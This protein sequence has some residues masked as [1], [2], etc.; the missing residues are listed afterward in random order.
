M[1]LVKLVK[2]AGVIGADGGGYS[3]H[4]KQGAKIASITLLEARLTNAVVLAGHHPDVY[5]EALPI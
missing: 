5:R 1:N 2:Q 3:A 4:V